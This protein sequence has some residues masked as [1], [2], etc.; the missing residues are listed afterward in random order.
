MN[1]DACWTVAPFY[2]VYETSDGRHVS[3]GAIERRFYEELLERS[4]LKGEDLP[5]QND[6]R[7]WH[8]LRARL[9]DVFATRTCDAWCKLLEGSDACFAPVLSPM[10]AV[11]HPHNVARGTYTRVDG[12]TQPQ[13]APR[14]GRTSSA[15]R[16]TPPAPGSDTAR[17]LADW[18]FCSDEV[19]E[20]Q[21]MGAVAPVPG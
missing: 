13:P 11:T 17:V 1:D 2:D 9:A 7:G 6:K 20:L 8:K 5:A 19:A 4:G 3:V 21:A 18:G 14:F 15:L 12:A 10:D 16:N